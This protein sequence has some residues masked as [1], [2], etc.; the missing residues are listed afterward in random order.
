MV[1]CFASNG[2]KSQA[3]LYIDMDFN[4]G[5]RLLASHMILT[6]MV[7]ILILILSVIKEIPHN[8]SIP[9]YV[10]PQIHPLSFFI[11]KHQVHESHQG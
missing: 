1:S 7:L 2:S 11:N 3:S 8:M 5:G 4:S 10:H 9:L 6:P